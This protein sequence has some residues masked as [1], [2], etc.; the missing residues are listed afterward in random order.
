MRGSFSLRRVER[1]A[2]IAVDDD[3]R[4]MRVGAA[5]AGMAGAKGDFMMTPVFVMRLHPGMAVA[6]PMASL[7][8]RRQEAR[9]APR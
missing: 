4:D 8:R 7:G 3:G 6:A 5:C 9:H 1:P 2:G